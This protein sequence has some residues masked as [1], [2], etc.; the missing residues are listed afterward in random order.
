MR[1]RLLTAAAALAAASALNGCAWLLGHGD[2]PQ[3]PEPVRVSEPVQTLS[4]GPLAATGRFLG[5]GERIVTARNALGRIGRVVNPYGEDTFV[6]RLRLEN[7]GGEPLVLLPEAATLALG[8]GRVEAART[9]DDY[10][11]RWPTWAVTNDQQGHDQNAAYTFVLDSLLIERVLPPGEAVEG[12]LAFPAGPVSAGLTLRLP[13]RMGREA[14][15]LT[16][17]WSQR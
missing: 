17:T 16:M 7:R 5:V 2:L 9:L 3:P 12:R 4:Q 13:Y 11:K 10:R 15:A 14:H 8:E 1:T 6:F